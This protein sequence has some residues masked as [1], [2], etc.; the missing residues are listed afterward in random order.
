MSVRRG[1]S[2]PR[3]KF[4]TGMPSAVSRAVRSFVMATEAVMIP[5]TR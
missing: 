1:S 2:W 4:T 5:S 3:L